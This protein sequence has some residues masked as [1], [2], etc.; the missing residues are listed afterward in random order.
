MVSLCHISYKLYS[1]FI[2]FHELSSIF[3]LLGMLQV[4]RNMA[5]V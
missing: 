4:Q 2:S 1:L 5:I 3:L